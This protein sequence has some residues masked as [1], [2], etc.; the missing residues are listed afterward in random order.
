MEQWNKTT[1]C[2]TQWNT[3]GTSPLKV[4]A[5]KVLERN[6][7]GNNPGTETLKSVPL[8]DQTVPLRGTNVEVG[9]KGE[10]DN[11][12]YECND[13]DRLGPK[14]NVSV[15]SVPSAGP[16]DKESLLYDFEERLAIAKYDGQQRPLQAE[17]IAYL[18]AFISVLT[19]LPQEAYENS[20]GEDWLD[21]RITA[22]KEWFKAQNL[23]QPK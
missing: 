21:A 9:C 3:A 13:T 18:D 5:N 10:A 8:S 14:T 7:K 23:F 4:L 22:A 17:R 15:M 1:S 16:F 12:P 6:T 11:F 20:H 19:T 2:D